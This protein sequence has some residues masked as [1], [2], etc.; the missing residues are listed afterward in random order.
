MHS[1]ASTLAS[2]GVSCMCKWIREKATESDGRTSP[3]NVFGVAAW[4][5]MGTFKLEASRKLLS[6]RALIRRSCE[7]WMLNFRGWVLSMLWKWAQVIGKA[8]PPLLRCCS[9][10]SGA[11]GLLY[12]TRLL[13][14]R[15]WRQWFF[16]M[17]EIFCSALMYIPRGP[18]THGHEK[19]CC[20]NLQVCVCV[21]CFVLV[22]IAA[23]CSC[24][25]VRNTNRIWPG[26]RR[27]L[28]NNLFWS[29]LN[30][31]V[32]VCVCVCVLVRPRCYQFPQ[33]SWLCR[34]SLLWVPVRAPNKKGVV[35]FSHIFVDGAGLLCCEPES[36]EQGKGRPSTPHHISMLSGQLA[37]QWRTK[38]WNRF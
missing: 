33:F 20:G 7:L 1:C 28:G 32:C 29:F 38:N 30:V 23:A 11:S 22:H 5:L 13:E 18:M 35:S 3:N 8:W 14:M 37:A 21:V 26:C 12:P 4:V 9:L 31:C 24:Q 10:K 15:P 36:G 27:A 16:C 34:S 2:H 6:K 25:Y 17:R 19:S